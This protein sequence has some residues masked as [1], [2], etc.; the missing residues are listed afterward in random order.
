MPAVVFKSV[1]M[2]FATQHLGKNRNTPYKAI[3]DAR[4]KIKQHLGLSG[5]PPQELLTLFNG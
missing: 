2:D 5:H 1:P 4:L 3:Y